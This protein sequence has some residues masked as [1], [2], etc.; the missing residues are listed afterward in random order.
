MNWLAQHRLALGLVIGRLARTPFSSLLAMLVIGVALS[1]PLSLYTLV[2]NIKAVAGSAKLEPQITLFLTPGASAD[3]V[4]QIESQLKKLNT[5][6]QF[7]FIP[8]DRA[9]RE[10]LQDTGLTDVAAGLDRN[11]LPDAFIIEPQ[12]AD[13]GEL[14][15]LRDALL[16]LPKVDNVLLDTVWAKRLNAMVSFG[17]DVVLI[18][19]GLLGFALLVITGNTVRLQILSQRDE[20]EISTL[21][22]AT[23]AFIR[24]PFLYHG[25]LQGLGGGLAAWLIVS[26]GLQLLNAS[27]GDLAKLYA[28]QFLLQPIDPKDIL[29]LLAFSS[30]LGWFGAFLA[31]GRHLRKIEVKP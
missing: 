15:S 21:I 12:S 30:A 29:S 22:G 2:G 9:L 24:R 4:R 14:E 13:P 3:S 7:R 5:V 25:L 23:D 11:P 19:A 31:V 18:L 26:L 10:L 16:E 1:L 27:I 8:R 6:G 20:I 28:A 17:R